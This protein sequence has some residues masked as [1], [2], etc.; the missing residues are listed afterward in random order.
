M[1]LL[2]YFFIG[3]FLIL[4]FAL[5]L[6]LVILSMPWYIINGKGILSFFEEQTINKN[7][8]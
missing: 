7:E 5:A 8:H 1:L 3:F 6:P 4:A 2:L